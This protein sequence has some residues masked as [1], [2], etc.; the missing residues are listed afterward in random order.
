M[1]R[2]IKGIFSIFFQEHKTDELNRE[3]A[4]E[5]TSTMKESLS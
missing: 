4:E 2:K 3:L 5:F 1:I